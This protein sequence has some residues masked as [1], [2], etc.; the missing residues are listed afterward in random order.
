MARTAQMVRA[1]PAPS[2]T[3][4]QTPSQAFAPPI[5]STYWSRHLDSTSLGGRL[6]IQREHLGLKQEEVA[7]RIGV[8]RTAYSQYE[9]RIVVPSLAKIIKLA[10]ALETTPEWI[11]FGVGERVS[12][13]ELAYDIP[14]K[15]WV[16]VNVCALNPQW[17]KQHLPDIDQKTLCAVRLPNS[18]G[19]LDADDIAI[20]Q[21]EVKITDKRQEFLYVMGA[22]VL[23]GDLKRVKEGIEVFIEKSSETVNARNVKV[24]GRMVGHMAL[25]IA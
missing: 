24:L 14:S 22:D 23:V 6:T 12:M 4:Q 19:G 25:S 9:T 2:R 21:R 7:A 20:V 17:V 5:S 10:E 13:P 1:E 16:Q 8:A 18:V 15:G 11:A 3:E